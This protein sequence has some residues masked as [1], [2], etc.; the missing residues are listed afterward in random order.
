MK[1]FKLVIEY[2]GS[3]FCGW[4]RQKEDRTVQ[5]DLEKALK[6]ITHQKVTVTGSGRTDAGVHA[7]AQTASFRCDTDLGPDVFQKA[8]N[9]LVEDDIVIKSCESSPMDFHARFDVKNKTYQ[10]RI[11]NRPLPVAVGRQFVWNIRR[12]LN[13]AAMMKAARLFRG[14]LDFKAFEASGS[15]RSHTVRHVT[16]SELTKGKKGLLFFEIEANGFL[17]F[18]VRNIVGTLVEVGAGKMTPDDI[19][20]IFAAGDRSLAGPTAPPHGLFLISVQY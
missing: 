5:G 9:S 10:Y 19:P 20:K 16:K 8:L 3:G 12:P 11:L 17:R 6:I 2:D 4:Q 7:L 14:K 18:M 15:P 13:T 1:N